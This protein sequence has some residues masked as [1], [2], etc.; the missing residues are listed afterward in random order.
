MDF[1]SVQAK[2]SSNIA[3]CE[4]GT[5]GT[6]DAPLLI[7]LIAGKTMDV[8][9]VAVWIEDGSLYVD[10]SCSWWL[11]ETHLEVVTDPNDFP[12]TKKGNPKPGLF[13]Y[14]AVHDPGTATVRYCI[15]LS[16][17][18]DAEV[19][20]FAAHAEVEQRAGDSGTKESAWAAGCDFSGANWA[21]YFAGAVPADID[22]TDYWDWYF[23]LGGFGIGP[24]VWYIHQTDSMLACSQGM[25]GEI[26]GSSVIFDMPDFGVHMEGAVSSDGSL[27]SGLVW[28]Q[29][30]DG[31]FF[32][33]R[34]SSA[35]FGHLDLTGDVE[36]TPFSLDTEYALGMGGEFES[37]YSYRF[38]LNTGWFTGSLWFQTSSEI[39]TM[40]YIVTEQDPYGDDEINAT[41]MSY[42]TEQP[43]FSG[44]VV[45]EVYDGTNLSG[46]FDLEFDGGNS[47]SAD[48]NVALNTG[49]GTLTNCFWNG[50]PVSSAMTFME[51]KVWVS[52][53]FEVYYVDHEKDVFLWMHVD[54]IVEIG[55]EY[56]LPDEAGLTMR[57]LDQGDGFDEVLIEVP[58]TLTVTR[59]DGSGVAGQIDLG[60]T[61]S[62]S[63][64]VSWWEEWQ[65]EED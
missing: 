10:Y 26:S 29:M 12:H 2:A 32:M 39:S 59:Y 16:D 53:P 40:T 3:E 9:S 41:L 17:F 34:P 63:F 61:L 22:L 43:A 37:R 19:L 38:D 44:Q 48:F 65:P 5:I 30:G 45:V 64:D 62:G 52:T 35:P 56:V 46:N 49:S 6:D 18:A 55:K 11:V 23:T 15:D 8:G 31:E 60:D 58:G 50:N 25:T 36:D 14:K 1:G 47:F 4:P 33:E 13:T 20:Y 24:L 27:I 21:M 28:S 54:G 7:P 51:D 57:W 42:Y